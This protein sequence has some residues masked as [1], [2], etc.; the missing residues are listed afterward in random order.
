MKKIFFRNLSTFPI[1]LK[2]R[3]FEATKTHEEVEEL[4]TQRKCKQK[5]NTDK[6]VLSMLFLLKSPT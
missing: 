5:V 6:H 2:L 4:N 1:L 3:H